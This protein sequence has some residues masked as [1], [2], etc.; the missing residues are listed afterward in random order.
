MF[1]DDEQFGQ[2]SPAFQET[3]S[4]LRKEDEE[5]APKNFDLQKIIHGLNRHIGLILLSTFLCGAL[6]AWAA[7]YYTH[8]YRAEAVVVY[9]E[10][11]PKTIPGG[12]ALTNLS[13]ITAID[14]I[15]L[16]SNFQ[17]VKAVLGLDMSPKEIEESVSVPTPRLNSHLIRIV[18]KSDNPHLAA[19]ISNTLAK[20]AVK[21]SQDFQQRQL[22]A[23]LDNFKDQL[24]Q[25]LKRNSVEQKE[26]EDFKTKH[27]YFE[28]TADYTTLLNE[29]V[30]LRS[31]LQTAS[32]NYNSLLVEY[33]NLKSE[34]GK[35]DY[36]L[37]SRNTYVDPLQTR[38]NTL[39]S[40][41]AEARSKYAPAN[42][43]IKIMEEELK[44]L[45]EKAKEANARGDR[46]S[47]DLIKL[48]GKVR[49]SQKVKQDL[50][51][52]VAK[53]EKDLEVLPSAQGAFTKLLQNNKITTDEIQFL[54]QSIDTIQLLINVPKGNLELYQLANKPKPLKDSWIIPLLP[55]LGLGFGLCLGLLGAAGL[56]LRDPHLWTRK[57]IELLYTI[58]ALAQI[59]ILH[60]L[61]LENS[62]E[63]F[64]F[65]VRVVAEKLDRIVSL[66]PLKGNKSWILT[67]ASAKAGDGKSTLA[68]QL[69][70]YYQRVGKKVL[71]LDM[72]PHPTSFANRTA[73][74]NLGEFFAKQGDWQ[75]I[76]IP[77]Q[78]DMIKAWGNDPYLKEVIKSEPMLALLEDLR[79]R[80]DLVIID[81]PGL[82]DEHYTANLAAYSDLCLFVVGSPNSTKALVNESLVELEHAGVIP[83]G[84]VLNKVLPVYIDDTKIKKALN[85]IEK[86]FW[87]KLIFWRR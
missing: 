14:L 31:K 1:F 26:I 52:A 72:D 42:P 45:L 70:Q 71:L 54:H 67:I 59:P 58:P 85:R 29:L 74:L 75:S 5:D 64:L 9:Q 35:M 38:I 2:T 44:A 8:N 73:S 47:P 13:L 50:T 34:Q 19:D 6:G 63:K 51:A 33:E 32:L 4:A 27:Q 66:L 78:P 83:C 68:Y 37:E 76:V 56:E 7:W 17:A 86:N 12:I 62:N 25:A 57:Q 30:T 61:T 18:T 21:N 41:L 46:I 22:Q 60:N 11:L 84:I 24:S 65:F 10:D 69:A 79:K 3:P 20:I 43:K 16:P 55:L 23:Q 81:A 49:S 36:G 28:M 48:Q 80:Y 87:Q 82:I 15:S 40:S 39:E 53:L 77:G